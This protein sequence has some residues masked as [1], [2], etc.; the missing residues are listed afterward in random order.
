MNLT[1][2]SSPVFVKHGS[3]LVQEIVDLAGAIDFLE[4]RP[5]DRRNLIHETALRACTQAHDG[6]KP[7]GV[8]RDAFVAFAKRAGILEDPEAVMPWIAASKSGS[9]K[10]QA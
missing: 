4:E 7:L 6:L 1:A 3:Y 9:G 2:F 5:E 8:A 10:V